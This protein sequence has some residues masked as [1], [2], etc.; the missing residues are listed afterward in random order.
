MGSMEEEIEK[1]DLSR[2]VEEGV[3]DNMMNTNMINSKII[4]SSRLEYLSSNSDDKDENSQENQI[5]FN[6]QD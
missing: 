6:S 2:V 4:C 3:V 1:K 5:I